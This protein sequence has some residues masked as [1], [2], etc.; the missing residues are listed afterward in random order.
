MLRSMAGR[1]GSLREFLADVS[2][3]PDKEGADESE[4]LTL[5]TVHSAKGLEWGWVFLIGL[6]EGVFPS[7]RSIIDND[8]ANIEEEQRLFYVA[9]TRAKAE[10]HLSLYNKGGSG[11]RDA[12]PF[13]K[14][15]DPK[16]VKET[17][18]E[19]V[20]RAMPKAPAFNRFGKYR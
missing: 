5:S 8:A 18:E 17:V 13:S 7:S 19:K 11:E 9:V 16:N 14:F 1:S 3:D 12:G 20:P 10:L 15:L 6:V 2:I 4:Y